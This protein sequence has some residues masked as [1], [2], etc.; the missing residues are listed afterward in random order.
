MWVDMD[1]ECDTSFEFSGFDELRQALDMFCQDNNIS[2]K[3]ISFRQ[4]TRMLTA[5]GLLLAADPV[6]IH[7]RTKVPRGEHAITLGC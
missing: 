1:P 5:R 6:Q 7:I 4:S 2:S 3:T